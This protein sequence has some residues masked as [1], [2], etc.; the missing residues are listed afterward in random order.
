MSFRGIVA[1]VVSILFAAFAPMVGA[2][3]VAQGESAP[4]PVIIVTGTFSPSLA[5]Q[6]FAVR[7]R[8]DGYRTFIFQLPT[9]G[10]QDI[11]ASARELSSFADDV[12]SQTGAEKVDL[13]GHS[14]GGLVARSYVKDFGGSRS[15]DSLITLGTPNRGTKIANLADVLGFGNCLRVTACEQMAVGSSYLRALNAGDDTIGEVAYT[16]FL[17]T[18]DELVRPVRKATLFNGAVNVKLQA[19]CPWR[20]VGHVGLIL[21][22]TVYSGVRQALEHLRPISLRCFAL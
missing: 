8:H 16:T 4:D 14:Q 22:G 21:D 3:A 11:N 6:P 2:P 1:T 18:F 20:V 15:V 7:L 19:Q 9:L 5:N 10:T 12:R 13:I 17:T